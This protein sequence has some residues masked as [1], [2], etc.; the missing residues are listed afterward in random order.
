MSFSL[1]QIGAR[2][3]QAV[4]LD[5]L[6][7]NVGILSRNADPVASDTS[8]SAE[9]KGDT[10]APDA[11]APQTNTAEAKPAGK[12]KKYNSAQRI[13]VSAKIAAWWHGDVLARQASKARE[14]KVDTTVP[15]DMTRWGADRLKLV[16]KL[17]GESFLEPGGAARTRKLFAHVMPNSK[18]TVLDLTAGLGG[19]AFTLAQDQGLWMDAVEPDANLAAEALRAASMSG[20]AKQVPVSHVDLDTIG[21][22][23]NKY[24]LAYTRERLFALSQKLELLTAAAASLKQGGSLMITDLMVAS[25]DVMDTEGYQ[26][27]AGSEPITP[28]PW[29]MALYAKSLQDCDLKVASRQDLSAEYLEDIHAG[30]T[31]IS[32]ALEDGEFDNSLGSYLLAEGEVW[33][34]RTKAMQDGIISYCRIIARRTD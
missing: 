16:Q 17:W 33:A 20:L 26:T 6:L 12:A 5:R 28:Q 27:W 34:G 32:R 4:P 11:A 14:T 3:R 8:D 24:H 30:W 9:S 29:T 13:P 18:Q 2:A 25:A 23:N 1:E 19:T 31:R 21:V 22:P 7:Q 10:P 15:V